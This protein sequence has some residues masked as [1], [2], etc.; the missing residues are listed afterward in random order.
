M[1]RYTT[2]GFT[3]GG[4]IIKNKLFFFAN[5]EYSKAPTVVNRWR[6]SKDGVANPD[7]YISRTTV[8][9]ME[10]VKKHLAGYGYDAG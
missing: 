8:E 1:D 10:K 7:L 3:L 5:F 6:P 2:Y 4:P 9:D